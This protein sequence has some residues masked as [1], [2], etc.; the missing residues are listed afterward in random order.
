MNTLLLVGIGGMAGS[1]ARFVLGRWVARQ[2]IDRFPWGTWSI[3]ISGATLLGALTALHPHP[4][5]TLLL[6]DGFLGAFTTF[7]T[8][9]YETCTLI[10]DKEYRLALLYLWGSTLPGLLGFA[11][12]TGLVHALR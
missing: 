6:A 9:M 12:G 2:W 3:N 7:S 4:A 8:Y 1:L 10:N 11:G 5:S